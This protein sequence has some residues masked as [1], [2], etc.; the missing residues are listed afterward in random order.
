MLPPWFL[1]DQSTARVPKMNFLTKENG[2]LSWLSLA[3]TSDS[4]AIP[5]F[6]SFFFF[7]GGSLAGLTRLELLTPQT[8]LMAADT[9]AVKGRR[10]G[11]IGIKW[12]IEG[13]NGLAIGDLGWCKDP[14]TSAS[15]IR[16]ASKGDKTFHEPKWSES[17]FPDAFAGTMGQLLIAL[18][19]GKNP[20]SADAI[21]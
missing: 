8:S 5:D 6:D 4:H 21:I 17:W 16:F 13:L 7:I 1:P 12:R 9:Y 20:P 19:T 2:L 10:S 14:Y 18:E 15:A 11:D 3:I